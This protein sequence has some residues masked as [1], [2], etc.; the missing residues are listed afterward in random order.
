MSNARYVH[1]P[2]KNNGVSLIG[3]SKIS[4]MAY[5]PIVRLMKGFTGKRHMRLK[6][7]VVIRALLA[8]DGKYG[9]MA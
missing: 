9:G 5:V 3:L 4:R 1:M 2:G 8:C 7:S 6:C